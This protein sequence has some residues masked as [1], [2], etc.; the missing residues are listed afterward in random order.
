MI[1]TPVKSFDGLMPFAGSDLNV[2]EHERDLAALK[3]FMDAPQARAVLCHKG[4]VALAPDLS[5]ISCKPKDLIGANIFDPGPVFLGTDARGPIFAFSVDMPV[6]VNNT[7]LSAS[8]FQDLRM[9]GGRMTPLDMALAGRARSLFDWH[10][11]HRFCSKCGQISQPRDGGVK[12]RCASANCETEHFPRVNPVAIMLVVNGDHCLL[13]RGHGWPEGMY[14]SLAGFVS[15]GESLEEACI[16][17]V[18]EEVNLDVHSPRYL[19]SQPW[20]WP[21]Q[22]MM[23]MI[24]YA[25]SRDITID[26]NEIDDARWFS[27]D[28]VQ[29]VYDKQ[30]DAFLRPARIAIAHHLLKF[31]LAE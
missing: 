4:L 17:E 31:W 9:V 24:C 11:N 29:A 18:K 14:S 6:T 28:T 27:K 16:R 22:L 20:P 19:F 1:D 2:R 12:R 23:G 15:P 3:A 8:D 7:T 30:S 21:S 26:K 5:L 10:Y 13:G 25:D